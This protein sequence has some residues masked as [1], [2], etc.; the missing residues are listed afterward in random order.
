MNYLLAISLGPVQ[1]FIA[2]ARRT[3]DLQAGSS[4]LVELA[5]CVA[6]VVQANGA[7]RLIFPGDIEKDGPNKI[8][9]R[10]IDSDSAAVAAL[11]ALA[12]QSAQA[13]LEEAWTKAIGEMRGNSRHLD[14]DLASTQIARFLEFN[15]AWVPIPDE[16]AYADA[17]VAVDRLLAGRKALRQFEQ[18]DEARNETRKGRPKSPL[19]P[20]RDCALKTERFQVPTTCR[21]Y[22][23]WLK[24]NETLDAVSLLKRVRGVT[25]NSDTPSTSDMAVRSI[26]PELR[27]AAPQEVAALEALVKKAEREV[28]LG[29]FMFE[30]RLADLEAEMQADAEESETSG[31]LTAGDFAEIRKLRH[32]A[33]NASGRFEYP[34]YYAVLAADG[35]LMGRLL[36]TLTKWEHHAA[37]SNMLSDFAEEAATTVRDFEGHAV[38]TGG[39]DVLALLPANR[40][41]ACAASL[42]ALFRIKMQEGMKSLGVA[43]T[44]PEQ[45]GTLSVGIAITHCLEPLQVSL[46]YARAAERDAKIK[47]NSLAVRLHT[48][49]GEP[50]TVAETWEEIPTV[51]EWASLIVAMRGELA[52]GFPYELRA[53]AQECRGVSLSSN[54]IQ[55]EALRILDRKKGGKAESAE[56]FAALRRKLT[57]PDLKAVNA[58]AGMAQTDAEGR[59]LTADKAGAS[60]IDNADQLEEFAKKLVIVRFLAEL[61]SIA[62]KENPLV[63]SRS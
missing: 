50:M 39:D 33:L 28:D 11:A 48:R 12:R 47:R 13:F 52:R 16:N 36:N 53:L 29:D 34:P 22:P 19:D 18:C 2:A 20:S 57:P 21:R 54:I 43:L 37:V 61:E 32:N 49:G 8:L 41:L 63:S 10:V 46:E 23:L 4:L 9:A 24:N 55:R 45:G 42:A 31:K 5:Q 56:Q 44:S 35:D 15:A 62:P 26:L 1:E 14:H 30:G 7:N 17:R 38:Y 59:A 6:R 25:A 3:A 60:L 40:A 27:A 58:T 51:S